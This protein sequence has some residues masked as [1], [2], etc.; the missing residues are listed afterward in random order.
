MVATQRWIRLIG[1]SLALLAGC[2]PNPA[3][4][5]KADAGALYFSNWEGEIGRNTLPDE[6]KNH[7]YLMVGGLFT[8]FALELL[9][10]PAIYAIWKWRG[11][12]QGGRAVPQPKMV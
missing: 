10:Y 8:S 4:E 6:A 2:G 11:E 9:V 7:T 1:A 3:E 5:S 12:M